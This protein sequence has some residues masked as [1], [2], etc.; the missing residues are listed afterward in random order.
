MAE[1][2]SKNDFE[3]GFFKQVNKSI[4]GKAK[5]NIPKHKVNKLVTTDKT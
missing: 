1:K 4:F 2:S 3:K 5:E